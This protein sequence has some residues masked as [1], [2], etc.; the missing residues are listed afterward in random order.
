MF[1]KVAI[2]DGMA[3]TADTAYAIANPGWATI[4]LGTAAFAVQIYADFSG[5]SDIARGVAKLFGVELMRNFN[6]PYFA[7]SPRD[8]WKSMAYQPFDL[9]GRLSL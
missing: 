3:G 2:A 8:F 6:Q 9:V 1:K 4:V 7:R 5:Y